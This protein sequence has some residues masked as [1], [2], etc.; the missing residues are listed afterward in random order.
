MP[1]L[2]DERLVVLA[3][4][5]PPREYKLKADSHEIAAAVKALLGAVFQQNWKIIFGGHP[6]ISPLVLMIA[7]DYGRKDSVAIYQ[8]GYFS[9]HIGAATLSLAQEQ[10]GEIVLIPNDP[11]ELPPP[12]DETPDPTKCPR[13]LSAM[14]IAMFSRPNIAGLVLIG[15]DSGVWQ[16]ADQFRSALPHRPIIPIGSPGGAAKDLIDSAYVPNMDLELRSAI[17]TSRNYLFLCSRIIRY[18]GTL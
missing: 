9:N 2:F 12:P 14:R 3:A 4:S 18:L 6:S 8:S 10:F 7:R 13:S 16:E 15:G 11:S 5:Y 17:A 1:H